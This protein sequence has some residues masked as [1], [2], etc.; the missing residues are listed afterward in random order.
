VIEKLG[1]KFA[2]KTTING[3]EAVYFVI[4]SGDYQ[5]SLMYIS[6]LTVK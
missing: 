6:G 2:R 4:N 5:S 3:V 1:M